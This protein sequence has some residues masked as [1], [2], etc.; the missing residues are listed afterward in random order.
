MVNPTMF[1]LW[2]SLGHPEKILAILGG[3][4][5]GAFG[6]GFL[7][8]MLSRAMTTRK[9]PPLPTTAIRCV[10][11]VALGI[12]TAMWI[13]QGGGWGPGGAGGP[14]TTEGTDAGNAKSETDKGPTKAPET[15]TEPSKP[16]DK[17][18]PAP[19]E[20]V[21]RIE[22]LPDSALSPYDKG[23]GR[24]YKVEGEDAQHPH[25]LKEMTDFIRKRLD[26]KPPLRRLDIV[27]RADSPDKSAGRV[28]QLREMIT[29]LAPN[30][31]V[32]YPPR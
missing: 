15:S 24:Y 12:L 13:W 7:A 3:A 22:A 25:T 31:N 10:G 28:K 23:E 11:G 27:T 5:V 21:L 6:S 16:P 2:E 4:A 8:Q 14:G 29:G 17:G 32:E 30:L 9:L 18:Q 20:T 26:D 1:A 19:P